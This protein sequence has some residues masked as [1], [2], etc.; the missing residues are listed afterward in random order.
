MRYFV[1][2]DTG[3]TATK[4]SV[5]D[6]HGVEVG[7]CGVST[8]ALT[9]SPGLVERDMEEMWQANCAVVKGALERSGVRAQDVAGIG[10]S[11]HGKGL[12]LWGKD[13]RPAR[14]GEGLQGQCG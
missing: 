1:G 4:A 6:E 14:R 8:R 11:G 3:G 13:G 5:F 10:V 9:P 2:L 7:S 12:Y